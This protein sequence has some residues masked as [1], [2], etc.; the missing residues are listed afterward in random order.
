MKTAS[1]MYFS[2]G[3]GEPPA[4][5][6]D[7]DALARKSPAMGPDD[8]PG[9]LWS[10]E[11]LVDLAFDRDAWD[12]FPLSNGTT[13]QANAV[14]LCSRRG[15]GPEFNPS[16]FLRAI[17]VPGH[18]VPCGAGALII[19]AAR[20]VRGGSGLPQRRTLNPDGSMVWKV[21]TAFDDLTAFADRVWEGRGGGTLEPAMDDA[22]LD[23]AVAA[24]VG[25]N[26]RF[27]VKELA[28]LGLLTTELI[29][30][31]CDSLVDWPAVEAAIKAL[32]DKKKPPVS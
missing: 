10:P 22:E 28:A 18:A 29:R 11:R 23:A 27:G 2:T 9:V 24:A 5:S 20:L 21:E 32:A 7:R 15:A 25:V 6:K 12:V 13:D 30:G 17:V 4:Y 26:Y 31:V 14:W 19:P 3:T 1:L 16:D 8:K